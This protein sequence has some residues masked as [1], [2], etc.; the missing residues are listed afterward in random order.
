[1][2]LYDDY[3]GEWSDEEPDRTDLTTLVVINL[4]CD[5]SHTETE[6]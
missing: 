3:E 5:S 6:V 4:D 2:N 1:M